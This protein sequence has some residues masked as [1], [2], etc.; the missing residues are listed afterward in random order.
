MKLRERGE[1]EDL[2]VLTWPCALQYISFSYVA[3]LGPYFK[4]LEGQ[5]N[6]EI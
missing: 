2:S 3:G 5:A 1:V 4:L 6:V